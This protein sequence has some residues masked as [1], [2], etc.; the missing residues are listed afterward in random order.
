M[1]EG[2]AKAELR[3]FMDVM[4]PKVMENMPVM[5]MSFVPKVVQQMGEE[6]VKRYEK[7]ST[8]LRDLSKREEKARMTVKDFY[9][10][11]AARDAAKAEL[12]EIQA[13]QPA[14]R[15]ELAE[16]LGVPPA[17]RAEGSPEQGE[18]PIQNQADMVLK[19]DDVDSWAQ[20]LMGALEGDRTAN[21]VD[22]KFLEPS[23]GPKSD[24]RKM[25]EQLA[26]TEFQMAIAPR[27]DYRNVPDPENFRFAYAPLDEQGNVPPIHRQHGF[28]VPPSHP[29][30]VEYL[31]GYDDTTY[32]MP[33]ETGE[34]YLL[35]PENW[36]ESVQQHETGHM[37]KD[38][39][40][41]G[42][43][44]S[45]DHDTEEFQQRASQ[46]LTE[47]SAKYWPKTVELLTTY[48][49]VVGERKANAAREATGEER[50]KMAL[51]MMAKFVDKMEPLALRPDR[52]WV[53]RYKAVFGEDPLPK[54][55]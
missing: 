31:Q 3:R 2:Q 5:A 43:G 17:K 23:T 51:E 6:A 46:F 14:L 29:G 32:K 36:N 22:M 18:T 37:L 45:S 10:D 1:P 26:D 42:P 40:L 49:P 38:S 34:I 41:Y 39:V 7:V 33:I 16:A 27:T 28:Y 52:Y 30:G 53:R 9:A 12:A 21:A 11:K 8:T 50:E 15:Q 4:A 24:A 48:D 13:Q 47:T 19:G 20:L 44:V 54:K 25:M 55:K 35:N